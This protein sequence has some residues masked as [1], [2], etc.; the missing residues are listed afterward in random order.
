MNTENNYITTE[1]NLITN[2]NYLPTDINFFIDENKIIDEINKNN[3]N[4]LSNKNN[5]DKNYFENIGEDEDINNQSNNPLKEL[6]EAKIKNKEDQ[7]KT[8][9]MKMKYLKMIMIIR[10]IK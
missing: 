6:D 2:Q 3:N 8:L 10:Y 9:I 7:I 1:T 5:K 4:S